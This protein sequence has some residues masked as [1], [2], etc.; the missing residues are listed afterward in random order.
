MKNYIKSFLVSLAIINSNYLFSQWVS[1]PPNLYTTTD[2]VGIG[3]TTPSV[4]LHIDNSSAANT[5][6]RVSNAAGS[7]NGIKVG[8]DGSGNNRIEALSGPLLLF[9]G[10]TERVRMTSSGI[11]IGQSGTFNPQSSLH[12]HADVNSNYLQVATINCGTAGTDGFKVGVNDAAIYGNIPVAELRQQE[13]AHMVFLTNNIERARIQSNGELALRVVNSGNTVN[14]LLVWDDS[15]GELVKY[16]DVNTLPFVSACSSGTNNYITKWCSSINQIQNSIIYDNSTRAGIGTTNPLALFDII[17]TNSFAGVRSRTTSTAQIGSYGVWGQSTSTSSIFNIGTY[18]AA[19]NTSANIINNGVWGV[20]SGNDNLLNIGGIF[21]TEP[22]CVSDQI[23]SRLNI[24]VYAR[25]TG[26][27]YANDLCA[28]GIAGYFNG[29]VIVTGTLS[30]SDERLKDSIVEY[31]AALNTINRLLPKRYVFKGSAFPSMQLPVGGQIGFIAQQVDSVLP[32]L[33]TNV[34]QP[35]VYDSSGT[36]IYDTIHYKAMNY[37]GLIPIA[38]AGIQEQQEQIDSLFDHYVKAESQP[39]DSNYLPKWSSTN[40]S[41]TNS[42]IY[43]DGQHVGIPTTHPDSKLYVE[44]IDT[45]QKVIGIF[46]SAKGGEERNAGVEGR[47]SGYTSDGFNVG[48]SGEADSS[49]MANAGVIGYVN[50]EAETPINVGIVGMAGSSENQNIGG[51]FEVDNK[52]TDYG[53]YAVNSGGGLA[54]YFDGDVEVTGSIYSSSDAALKQNVQNIAATDALAKLLQLQPRSYEFSDSNAVEI[55]LPQGRQYGFL[56]QEVEQILP[57]LVT[58]V[59]HPQRLDN[60]GHPVGAKMDYKA[61]NYTGLIPLLVSAVKEQQT[62][63][64]SLQQVID[65]R[66]SAIEQRLNNCCERGALP[67]DASFKTE[68]TATVVELS[69]PQAVVLEQNVPNPFAEQTTINYYLPE[70]SG[71]AQ[72]VFFDMLGRTIKT[73]DAKSGY[74]S[75]TVFASNLSTGQYSYSLLINGQPYQTR[76]MIKTK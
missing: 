66:L 56:A 60:T 68:G 45:S 16:R 33:I 67:S 65:T 31:R 17:N 6:L 23:R 37:T 27:E 26:W 58:E 30:G 15:N 18:G 71:A 46:G 3:T 38:I 74:G 12:L 40:R 4:Q 24:G 29:D 44:N 10:T 61:I 51:Y 70:G 35:P 69:N 76:Q 43:D 55:N 2:A 13:D 57:G 73:V 1:S 39:T 72:V 64:D 28:P 34:I 54:G 50:Y 48:V 52:K 14:K 62:K 21:I 9:N 53:I 47:A 36:L 7:G 25:G 5:F 75:L 20:A 22:E 41:L 42:L 49:D 11:G 63:I 59:T 32:H 19:L 8:V